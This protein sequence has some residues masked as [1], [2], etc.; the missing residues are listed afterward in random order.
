MSGGLGEDERSGCLFKVLAYLKEEKKIVKINIYGTKMTG[1]LKSDSRTEKKYVC[2]YTPY[3][4][5]IITSR[6][7]TFIRRLRQGLSR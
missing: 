5:E 3:I 6:N 4:T 1:H 7:V 2:T